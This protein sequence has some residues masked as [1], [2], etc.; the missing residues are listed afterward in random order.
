GHT[1]AIDGRR[2]SAIYRHLSQ[3]SRQLIGCETVTQGAAEMR[4]KFMHAAKARDHTKIENAAFARLEC[5]V[6]PNCAPAIGGEQ[7]LELP[8]EVIGIGDRPVD[9]L[10]AQYFAPHRHS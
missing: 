5:V 3:N 7:L 10:I 8:I 1:V 2:E 4:L 9:I 6:T